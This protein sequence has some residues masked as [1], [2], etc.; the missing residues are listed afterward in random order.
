MIIRL[1]L[2]ATILALLLAL[3]TLSHAQSAT[4]MGR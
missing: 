4:L 3:S 2:S 1:V